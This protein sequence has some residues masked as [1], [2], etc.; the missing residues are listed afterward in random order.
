MRLHVG[1]QVTIIPTDQDPLILHMQ[2]FAVIER[3]TDEGYMVRLTDAR[4][5][6]YG[7]IP[8]ARLLPGWRNESG[9]FR[10]W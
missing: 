5:P 2:R 8:E 3:R 6:V 1:D 4:P 10:R 7:P 9:R